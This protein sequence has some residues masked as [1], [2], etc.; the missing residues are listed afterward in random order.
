MDQLFWPDYLI[1]VTF[2]VISLGIGVY[3]S[4]TGGRQKTTSEFI[5]ANRSLKVLPTALSLLVSFQS[6]LLILG[7]TAEMYSYGSNFF[8]MSMFSFTLAIILTMQ[9]AVPWIYPMK[10]VSVNEYYERRFKSKSVRIL[11]SITLI[12]SS[13]LYM[14]V[15]M[16]APSAAL[17]SVTGLP[18]VVSIPIMAVVTITYTAL[19]GMRA[20]IWTDVFQCFIMFG[21]ILAIL[22]KGL[23]VV[24]GFDNVFRICSESGRLDSVK[25]VIFC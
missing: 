5:M 19:G 17:E 2:L 12:I 8:I 7:M 22:I 11:A 15:A 23:V 10:L 4:L 20:V 24:G 9:V 3:H 18:I 21:G 6:A 14:G 1:L 16:Y 13:I 25:Y